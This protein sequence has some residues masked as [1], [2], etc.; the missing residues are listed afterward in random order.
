M[1]GKLLN[2]PILRN[3]LAIFK[4]TYQPRKVEYC[5]PNEIRVWLAPKKQTLGLFSVFKKRKPR[6]VEGLGFGSFTVSSVS[7]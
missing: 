2:T 4:N 1:F 3:L 7:F 6:G 5:F